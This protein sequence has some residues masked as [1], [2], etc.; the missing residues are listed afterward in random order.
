MVFGV[1]FCCFTILVELWIR[2]EMLR[3]LKVVSQTFTPFMYSLLTYFV[4]CIISILTYWMA[5]KSRVCC[6]PNHKLEQVKGGGI[7]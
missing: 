1:G 3:K 6:G 4:K 2:E 7:A 5:P